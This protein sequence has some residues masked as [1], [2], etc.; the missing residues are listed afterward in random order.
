MSLGQHGARNARGVS[1][2]ATVKEAMQMMK[3]LPEGC[4]VV[5]DESDVPIGI[6]TGRDVALKVVGSARRAS[7]VRVEE[8]MTRPVFTISSD[9]SIEEVTRSLKT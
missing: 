3:G 9:A 7:S 5:V 1:P 2:A 6:L 8:V 4:L